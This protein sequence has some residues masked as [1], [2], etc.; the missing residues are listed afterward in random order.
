MSV[1]A[2]SIKSPL[3]QISSQILFRVVPTGCERRSVVL[4]LPNPLERWGQ[5]LPD[6]PAAVLLPRQALSHAHR[7]TII[8]SG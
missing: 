3:E 7:I 5:F 6:R 4:G 1:P 2:T 8:G